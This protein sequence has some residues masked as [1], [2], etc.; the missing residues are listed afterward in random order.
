MWHTMQLCTALHANMDNQPVQSWHVMVGSIVVRYTYLQT[1]DF[2]DNL[3]KAASQEVHLKQSL[4][5]KCIY[6]TTRMLLI[7]R[8]TFEMGSLD[9]LGR[10]HA[11]D[12]TPLKGL[13][14]L[15]SSQVEAFAEHV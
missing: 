3:I 13:S 2:S 12:V 10:P 15:V 9:G 5:P 8:L 14:L 7:V 1:L 6:K 4:H 11:Q